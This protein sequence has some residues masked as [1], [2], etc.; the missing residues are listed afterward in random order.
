MKSAKDEILYLNDSFE[1]PIKYPTPQ[2]K[3]VGE[4]T[5]VVPKKDYSFLKFLQ[6]RSCTKY[7]KN[8]KREPT[9]VTLNVAACSYEDESDVQYHFVN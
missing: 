5:R 9:Y 6:H 3:D 1:F 8:E 7:N 2:K 4:F